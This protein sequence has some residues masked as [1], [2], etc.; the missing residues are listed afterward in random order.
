MKEWSGNYPNI[1]YNSWLREE[2]QNSR[3]LLLKNM[4]RLQAQLSV[5]ESLI[6]GAEITTERFGRVSTA[7]IHL[8][9]ELHLLV[10]LTQNEQEK[11][12]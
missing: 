9:E 7:M 5:L 8:M 1:S 4:V 11:T 10:I 2:A 12:V 3:N 6:S